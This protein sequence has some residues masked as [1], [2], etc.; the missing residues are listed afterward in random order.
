MFIAMTLPAD[1]D[2]YVIQS[3]L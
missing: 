3:S 2:E 1:C